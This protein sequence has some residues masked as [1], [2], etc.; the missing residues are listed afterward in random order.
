MISMFMPN[1]VD[2]KLELMGLVCPAQ[3]NILV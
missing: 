1:L 3:F 2:P